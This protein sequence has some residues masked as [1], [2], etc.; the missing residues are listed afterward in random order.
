MVVEP[1]PLLG[2]C[3]PLPHLLLLNPPF[4]CRSLHVF[5]VHFP[6]WPR[7]P[8]CCVSESP[9]VC[10]ILGSVRSSRSALSRY[11]ITRKHIRASTYICKVSMRDE[12]VVWKPRLERLNAILY[13]GKPGKTFFSAQWYSAGLLPSCGRKSLRPQSSAHLRNRLRSRSPKTP[14]ID[15]SIRDKDFA[16]I[17]LLPRRAEERA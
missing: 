6:A 8:S 10:Q 4:C 12:G 7:A 2:G 17:A 15:D 16:E 5:W 11:V 1:S 14:A 9:A 3:F 13:D